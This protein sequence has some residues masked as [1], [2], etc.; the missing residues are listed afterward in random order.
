MK[1][2]AVLL[3]GAACAACC[4][5]LLLPILAGSTALGLGTATGLAFASLEMGLLAA[6]LAA[7][8]F[9]VYRY[10]AKRQKKSCVCPPNNGCHAGTAC[11]VPGKTARADL[12][13][14][15]RRNNGRG[16]SRPRSPGIG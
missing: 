9:V 1:L 7:T 6:G 3:L 12:N 11:H 4:A 10:R 2:K 8:A 15:D 5:P 16:R 13:V 14:N